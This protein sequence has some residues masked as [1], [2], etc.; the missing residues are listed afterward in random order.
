M[1]TLIAESKTMSIRQMPVSISHWPIFEA[2]ADALARR[3]AHMDIADICT[4]L[5]VSPKMAAEARGLAY[6]FCDK[7]VG[8]KAISAFTGVVFRQLHTEGYDT[9]SMALMDRN[10][11]IVSSLYGLLRA[12]DTVKPYRLEYTSKIAPDGE[13][14]QRFWRP[15]LTAALLDLMEKLNENEVL[16]LLPAD[17]SKC[18]DWKEIRK[19]ATVCTADFATPVGDKVKSPHSTRLKEL[20]GHLLDTIVAERVDTLA[21]VRRITTA[22]IMP[23]E[24]AP[25]SPSSIRFLAADRKP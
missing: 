20:R 24:E 16:D 7:A 21:E 6:D 12:Y 13:S 14:L 25:A 19:H 8:L 3:L 2:E 5:R 17:A 11:M 23:D 4:D 9:D 10:V 1:I 15:K 18:L 22:Q